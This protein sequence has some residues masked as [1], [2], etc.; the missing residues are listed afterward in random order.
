M[1]QT[2]VSAV[3]ARDHASDPAL[4][5]TYVVAE[6]EETSVAYL[7]ELLWR[8]RLAIVACTAL[9]A[10]A[11]AAYALLRP[12]TYTSG[13]S[14]VPQARSKGANLSSL[15]AQVGIAVPQ[16]EASE[17]PQ[18]YVALL[19]TSEILGR[20]VDTTYTIASEAPGARRAVT[21]AE[22]LEA[23]GG[24]PAELRE[25]AIRELRERITASADAKTGIVR[26]TVQTESPELS[27]A[28][29]R[30]LLD[31]LTNYNIHSRQS[32]AAAER[33]FTERRLAE[34]R[35]ELR[36]AEDQ[37]QDFLSRNR[38]YRNS[39]QLN[40]QYD[41][42]SREITERQQ[43]YGTLTQSYEQAR[44]EE[45]RDTPVLS[46]VEPP[47]VPARNDSRGVA[48]FAVLGVFVGVIAGSVLAVL[49]ELRARRRRID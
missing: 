3:S 13:A 16:G 22:F 41:R 17:S 28:V 5:P 32:Q 29:T 12:A 31:E 4:A 11:G 35:R 18:F 44:I 37:L 39:P 20:A 6:D 49:L 43:V 34:V 47:V 23:E 8:H 7:G 21:I 33:A 42:L 24:T 30:R 27:V 36:A 19:S 10:V 46:L 9:L 15:A 2:P 38:D 45:V 48:R 26:F 1:T 25:D 40:F 14:F